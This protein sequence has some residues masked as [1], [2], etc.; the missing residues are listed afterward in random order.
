M[1][2][3]WKNYPDERRAEENEEGSELIYD[4]IIFVV[5]VFYTQ[6]CVCVCSQCNE[7]CFVITDSRSRG[8]AAT[9]TV[10]RVWVIAS[11]PSSAMRGRF[12]SATVVHHKKQKNEKKKHADWG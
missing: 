8:E 2:G 9:P 7:N 1:A 5:N 11:G 6:V 12:F 4:K 10:T 3:A